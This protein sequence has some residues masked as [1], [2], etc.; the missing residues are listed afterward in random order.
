MPRTIA[1]RD[2]EPNV[3]TYAE[4]Y[5]A[6][7]AEQGDI[8]ARLA[9]LA[10]TLTEQKTELQD[11]SIELVRCLYEQYGDKRPMILISFFPPY[12]ALVYSAGRLGQGFPPKHGAAERAVQLR[13]SPRALY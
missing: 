7:K 13:R 10:R 6:V 2:F 5:A 4:L 8:D 9:A 11:I 3:I 1:T 12:D